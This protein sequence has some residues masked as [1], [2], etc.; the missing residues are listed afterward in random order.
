MLRENL[1]GQSV[2]I[3]GA[4]S[5]IGFEAARKLSDKGAHVILAVRN[6]EKGKAAVDSILQENSK[7]SVEMM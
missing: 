2:I 7:V 4:N 3:T 5:G 6:E 1:S